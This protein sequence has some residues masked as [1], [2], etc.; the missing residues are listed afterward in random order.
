MQIG[1]SR[2]SSRLDMRQGPGWDALSA[3]TTSLNSKRRALSGSV[4]AQRVLSTMD[5]RS[6]RAPGSRIL[7]F[8]FCR[9]RQFIERRLNATVGQAQARKYALIGRNRLHCDVQEF[10]DRLIVILQPWLNSDL[11]RAQLI[12]AAVRASIK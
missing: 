10:S 8:S 1:E 5:G 2:P 9:V 3:S 12:S 7:V 11:W 4:I 6:W